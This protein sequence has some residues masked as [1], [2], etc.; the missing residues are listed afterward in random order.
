MSKIIRWLIACTLALMF[1]L[2][3]ACGSS[4]DTGTNQPNTPMD[5]PSPVV[6]T[7][8]VVTD[9]APLG[10]E[11]YTVVSELKNADGTLEVHFCGASSEPICALLKRGDTI[12]FVEGEAYGGE[13]TYLT[14][15]TRTI[16]AA[17]TSKEGK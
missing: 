8:A 16:S 12:T 10:G 2:M 15:V 4:P 6:R 1:S 17:D 13:A 11:S 9:V 7:T 3:A 14:E 5:D